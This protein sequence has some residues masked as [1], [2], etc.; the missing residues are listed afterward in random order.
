M[1]KQAVSPTKSEV[2]E[3]VT[4][5]ESFE[6]ETPNSKRFKARA[7]DRFEATESSSNVIKPRRPAAV[8]QASF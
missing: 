4:D 7:P 8:S 2:E 6:E 1:R 3:D 5:D